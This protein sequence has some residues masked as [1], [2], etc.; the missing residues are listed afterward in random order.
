MIVGMN[1]LLGSKLASEDFDC[2]VR[3]D[4]VCVHVTLGSTTCLEDDERE[5]VDEFTGDDLN[6]E[7]IK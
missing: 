4:F 7:A 3:D 6:R 2:A 5:M 1:G